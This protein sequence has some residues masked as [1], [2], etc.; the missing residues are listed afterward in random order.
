MSKLLPKPADNEN[1]RYFSVLH[2]FLANFPACFPANQGDPRVARDVQVQASTTGYLPNQRIVIGEPSSHWK[3]EP[4]KKTEKSRHVCQFFSS[5]L[6]HQCKSSQLSEPTG[7]TY[8]LALNRPG[9]V[10][11]TLICSV[12]YSKAFSYSVL[13]KTLYPTIFWCF[14]FIGEVCFIIWRELTDP[15]YSK[16]GH[17]FW[18]GKKFII[19]VNCKKK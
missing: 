2:A 13:Y 7:L 11:F 16:F 3:L 9:L 17:I 18:G 4:E 5:D 6:T 12:I 8:F 19:G 10:R 14:K 1:F 15:S